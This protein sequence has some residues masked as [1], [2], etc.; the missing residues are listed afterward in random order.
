MGHAQRVHVPAMLEL[1]LCG[2]DE[3]EGES[4]HYPWGSIYG[5]QVVAQALRAAGATVPAGH[6]PHSLQAYF[7][8]VGQNT[9][10]VRY[11]VER[12]R[13]GRS[14]ST[15]AVRADQDH[16]TILT[17]SASFQAPEDGFSMQVE[18]APTVPPPEACVIRPWSEHFERR[19]PGID[20][21]RGRATAW[22]RLSQPMSHDDPV[23]AACA[24]AFLTDDMAADA[25]GSMFPDNVPREMPSPFLF[26]TLAHSVWFHAD[27]RPDQWMLFDIRCHAVLGPRGLAVGHVFDRSGRHLAT[28]AQELL[29]RRRREA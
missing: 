17:L 7:L 9:R 16:G 19:V 21:L 10:P 26:A 29:V 27:G 18:V 15:R 12:Q 8:R 5:G 6:R 1:R 24:L 22:L 2:F 4:A 28:I 23:A 14:F 13:D 25:V 20:G 3:F 11:A